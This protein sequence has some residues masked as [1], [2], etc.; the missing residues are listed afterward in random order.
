MVVPGCGEIKLT[1][2]VK[3]SKLRG[4]FG[5]SLKNLDFRPHIKYAQNEIY[6]YIYCMI[7]MYCECK[8][9]T[10]D[11]YGTYIDPTYWQDS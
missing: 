7:Y 3:F 5:K 11:T 2:I 10:A 1:S 8:F 9:K 4:Y 6:M